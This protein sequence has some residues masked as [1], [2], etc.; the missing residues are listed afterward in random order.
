MS[1]KIVGL[2]FF[3]NFL[4]IIFYGS[5]ISIPLFLIQLTFYDELFSF[6]GILQN[7]IEFFSY[8]NDEYANILF[9]TIDGYAASDRNSGFFWEPKGFANVLVLA[10]I[11]NFVLHKSIFNRY[12]TIFLIALIT[13]FSTTGYI[14]L[15]LVLVLVILNSVKLK[16]ISLLLF[17][18]F[19]ILVSQLD[20]MYDK[21][22]YE[23]SLTEDYQKLLNEKR[24]FKRNAISLGRIGSFIVDFNDFQKKP[25]LGYGFQREERT[26]NRWI[27]LV[28]VNG[29]SDLMA[30]YGILGLIF[31]FISYRKFI[32]KFFNYYEIRGKWLMLFI[33][34]TIYFASTLTAH[35]LWLSFLFIHKIIPKKI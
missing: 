7:N 32:N 13:T 27:K 2:T 31:Y 18:P 1:I 28:R 33:F 12:G 26:Q 20:F 6:I 23:L 14:S 19:V 34:I 21:I 16:T 3:K 29:F 24:S 25:I 17:L 15:L 35:P 8:R 11:I 30:T 5:I 9:Y 10:I 22:V 4:R